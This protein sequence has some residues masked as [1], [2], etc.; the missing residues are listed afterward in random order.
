VP[1]DGAFRPDLPLFAS[2]SATA[3]GRA[4]LAGLPALVAAVE[5]EWDVRTGEPFGGGVGGWTAPATTADGHDAVLKLSFPHREARH[6]AAGLA[7]W[8]GRGAVRL[9]RSDPDRWALL[10]ERCRPGT[11]LVHAGLP[12]DEALEVAAASLTG[13]WSVPPP[14]DHPFELVDDV[15]AEWATMVRQRMDEVRPPYDAGLVALG[16]S[17]LDELPATATRRVVVHGDFNPGNVLAAEREPWLAID[18]KPMVGDPGYDPWPMVMQVRPE[19]PPTEQATLRD[20]AQRVA[21]LVGEPAD[22][23]LAWIVAR[24][25]ES[26]LW[27]AS[28]GETGGGAS[29][30]QVARAAADVARL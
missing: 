4:W 7:L 5:D 20:R 2:L 14:V 24:T 18:P 25:V 13:L 19:P 27:H 15:C 29:D 8:Q 6:E 3:E 9:L 26:A 22:R 12:A 1:V 11:P 28:R 21:A 23:V 30:M 16:A 17:L 10:L